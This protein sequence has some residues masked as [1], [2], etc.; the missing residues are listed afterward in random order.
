MS[1]ESLEPVKQHD[2]AKRIDSTS[3]KRELGKDRTVWRERKVK[4]SKWSQR[5]YSGV[6]VAEVLLAVRAGAPPE[7]PPGMIGGE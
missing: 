6:E 3:I 5:W 4:T 7:T 2:G 1:L